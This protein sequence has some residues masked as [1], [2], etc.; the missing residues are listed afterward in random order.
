M[1]GIGG[2]SSRSS[3][4]ASST[5]TP[6]QLQYE[7][8]LLGFLGNRVASMGIEGF[9][10]PQ[11]GGQTYADITAPQAAAFRGA[12]E[13]VMSPVDMGGVREAARGGLAYN[14]TNILAPELRSQNSAAGGGRWSRA[15]ADAQSLA[16]GG[17]SAELEGNLAD[18]DYR[19]REAQ[20]SRLMTLLA[21]PQALMAAT[22]PWQMN[23]QARLDAEYQEYSRRWPGFFAPMTGVAPAGQQQQS[24]SSSSSWS[25]K[26]NIG[27]GKSGGSQLF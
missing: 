12:G 6:A 8:Q 22:D 27:D 4:R 1:G 20:R 14:F 11:Y 2:G 3:S 21:S 10:L 19:S 13:A 16:F 15:N 9:A 17:A 7:Q 24:R 23:E 25:A 26:L 18:L 5:S